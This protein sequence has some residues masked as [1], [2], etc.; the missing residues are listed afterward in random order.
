MSPKARAAR[1]A[2]RCLAHRHTV[3]HLG[4]SQP[5]TSTFQRYRAF[6]FELKIGECK[7][8]NLFRPNLQMHSCVDFSQGEMHTV[9][10]YRGPTALSTA[11]QRPTRHS[12]STTGAHTHH[13]YNST[14]APPLFLQHFR[15]PFLQHYRGPHPP[16]LQHHRGPH[17]P[18][19]GSKSRSNHADA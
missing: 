12:Y 15:G 17:L 4:P 18:C 1:R 9:R 5:K 14:G 19:R 13:V 8:L 7:H 3:F 2:S 6:M 16:F 11:L 10:N